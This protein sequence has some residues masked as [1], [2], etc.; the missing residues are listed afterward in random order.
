MAQGPEQLRFSCSNTLEMPTEDPMGAGKAA[1]AAVSTS[2]RV[3]C[4]LPT[5]GTVLHCTK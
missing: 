3:Y 4:F 5:T 1:S 2:G